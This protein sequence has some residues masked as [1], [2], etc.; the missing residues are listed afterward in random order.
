MEYGDF[1]LKE[2]LLQFANGDIL[3]APQKEQ[4]LGNIINADKGNFRRF[5]TLGAGMMRILDGVLNSR[6]IAA[7]VVSN[8]IMDGWRIDTMDIS[9]SGGEANITIVEA[10]K[11]TDETK[12]LI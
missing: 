11:I 10:E 4:L 1:K 5:P 6:D 9:E 3:I 8:A 2:G 12:S 7:N